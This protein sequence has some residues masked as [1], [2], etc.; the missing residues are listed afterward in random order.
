MASILRR[1]ANYKRISSILVE[2]EAH[3]KDPF[4]VRP[5]ILKPP[6]EQRTPGPDDI[7][8]FPQYK[9]VP[10]PESVPYR[11]GKYRPPSIP[12]ITGRNVEIQAGS[13]TT[14]ICSKAR[15]T[16]GVPAGSPSTDPGVTALAMPTLLDADPFS[17]T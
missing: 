4:L 9:T 1:A 14:P 12:F 8:D 5:E 7:T 2:G 15:S 10:I 17:S 3:L 6:T 13:L 11:E 16:V